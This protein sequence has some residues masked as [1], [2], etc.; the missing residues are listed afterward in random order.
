LTVSRSESKKQALKA[1]KA[2]AKKFR[3]EH[4]GE[5]EKT[6]DPDVQEAIEIRQQMVDAGTLIEPAVEPDDG[7]IR[8]L[9]ELE[10]HSLEES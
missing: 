1:S 2:R 3:E 9:G 4:A 6:V 8:E 10:E 7:E 5:L